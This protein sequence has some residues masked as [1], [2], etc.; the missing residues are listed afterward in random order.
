M[1]KTAL[2]HTFSSIAH[3]TKQVDMQA[4]WLNNGFSYGRPSLEIIGVQEGADGI[5]KV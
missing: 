3:T 1:M 5:T 4:Y 2:Q